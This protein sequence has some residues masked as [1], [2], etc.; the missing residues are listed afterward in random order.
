M[1]QRPNPATDLWKSQT[2][3]QISQAPVGEFTP[4]VTP[5]YPIQY[6]SGAPLEY[7]NGTDMFYE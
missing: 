2:E 5:T 3:N 1:R 4:P 7:S 6:T